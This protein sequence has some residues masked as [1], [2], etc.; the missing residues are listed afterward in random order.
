M[1]Y[2]G[3]ILA[4]VLSTIDFIKVVPTQDK[5]AIKKA[6]SK[7]FTRLVIAIIIFFVPI[8]LDFILELVGFNNPTC[9]LL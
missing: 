6:S 4:L 2:I 8:I 1:Q 5:D 7:A 9:G 3:V